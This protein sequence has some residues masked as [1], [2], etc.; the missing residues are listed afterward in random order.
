[1]NVYYIPDEVEGIE[2]CWLFGDNFLAS[3]YRECFL[4]TTDE[5][6]IKENFEVEKFCNSRFTSTN[7]NILSRLQI[8]FVKAIEEKVKLLK[9]IIVMLHSD[10]ISELA[11]NESM[12]ATVIGTCLEWLVNEMSGAIKQH[13][14]DLPKKAKRDLDLIIYW[15]ALPHSKYLSFQTRSLFAKCNN[16]LESVMKTQVN[17]R[18]IKLKNDWN[19]DNPDYI[20]MTAEKLSKNGEFALWKAMDA[21]VKFNLQKREEFLSKE[22][23]GFKSN[24]KDNGSTKDHRDPMYKVFEQ[25]RSMENDQFHWSRNGQYREDLRCGNTHTRGDARRVIQGHRQPASG[26]RFLMP[27]I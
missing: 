24:H 21:S 1:M 5:W 17:M 4:K 8:T 14:K 26:G 15:L 19:I 13:S 18:M 10:L 20:N 16:V 27:R 3:T 2:Q 25:R 7:Q 6:F 11:A 22:S 23:R 9:M 12:P